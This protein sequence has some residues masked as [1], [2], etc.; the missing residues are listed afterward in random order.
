VRHGVEVWE[1]L[2]GVL[3]VP[4]QDIRVRN[5]PSRRPLAAPDLEADLRD[6][7]A[8]RDWWKSDI[9]CSAAASHWPSVGINQGLC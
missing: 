1:A 5:R 2:A 8:N 9:S 6:D 7:R 4:G 3:G